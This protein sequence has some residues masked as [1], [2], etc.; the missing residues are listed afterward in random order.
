MEDNDFLDIA[1]AGELHRDVQHFFA[2]HP[3]IT[4]EQGDAITAWIHENGGSVNSLNLERAYQTLHAL[5]AAPKDAPLAAD[6]EWAP[7]LGNPDRVIRRKK[8]SAVVAAPAPEPVV[9]DHTPGT[10]YWK[11]GRWVP[12]APPTPRIHPTVNAFAEAAKKERNAAF[13]NRRDKEFISTR[14][15]GID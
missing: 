3:G 7:D 4:A 2:A 9:E 14:I 6:E 1:T 15:G 13:K 8:P 5:K 11:N 10:G 12:I